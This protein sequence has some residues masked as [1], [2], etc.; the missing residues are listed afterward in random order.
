[1]STTPDESVSQGMVSELDSLRARVGALEQRIAEQAETEAMLRQRLE[2]WG[3]DGNYPQAQPA[4]AEQVQ[5]AFLSNVSHELRTPLNAILGLTEALQEYVYGSLNKRQQQILRTVEDNGRQL[6][7]LVNDM[8]DLA[9]LE[10]GRIHLHVDQMSLGPFCQKCLREVEPLAQQKQIALSLN[11]DEPLPTITA[12]PRRLQQI[13][14][15]LL[16]NAIKFTPDGGRVGL[17][18]RSDTTAGA[19]IA[20]VVW[21]TGIG[22]A[23]EQQEQ[24]FA[25]FVQGDGGLAR[26]Y[27]GAGL[28]LALVTR[29]VALHG[30]RVL[31]AS[32][33]AR[34]S[35]FTVVLPLDGPPGMAEGSETG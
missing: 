22:V 33:V 27:G 31:L 20:F 32:D 30:G 28:G 6:L 15:Q 4:S 1:M 25:S 8:L 34:G 10:A 11:L 26:H 17:E 2:Q 5:H 7:A 29:L 18:V 12:D 23:K 35:R 24:I 16:Q 9:N 3:K 13:V 14:F 21:D 19:G